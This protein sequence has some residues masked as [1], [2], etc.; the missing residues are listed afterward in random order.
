M[1]QEKIKSYQEKL[2]DQKQVLSKRIE[3][4]N[5]GL[6]QPM[7]ESIGELSLYDNHP[8]DIGDE[9]FE[10]GK[11]LS[12]R[13]N[14]ALE[15]EQVKRALKKID[16]GSYGICDRCGKPIS[17]ERLSAM[18]SAGLCI[19]C[20]KEEEVPDRTPR[21]IE[22]GVIQPPYGEHFDLRYDRKFGDG[23]V[24]PKFDGEDAWQAVASYGTSNTPQDIPGQAE[25]GYPD[26]YNDSDEDIGYVQDVEAIPYIKDKDG[27]AYEK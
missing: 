22:E 6:D 19:D 1:D 12:L 2:E 25:E 11:D 23:D 20:K 18:P 24:D 21:P 8:A 17:E 9:L 16:E 27:T 5:Q 10:R 3:G 7:R 15:Q 13:D 26:I 4:L 14:A